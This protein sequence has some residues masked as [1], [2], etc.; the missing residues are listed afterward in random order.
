MD[1]N[2]NIEQTTTTPEQKS[3]LESKL[4][5]DKEHL[6][7]TEVELDALAAKLRE[8]GSQAK[9]KL[10]EDA[11]AEKEDIEKAR[12]EFQQAGDQAR[13]KLDRMTRNAGRNLKNTTIVLMKN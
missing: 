11:R 3:A 8:D 1:D 7:K 4:E 5:A 10:E 9:E 13:A 6:E 12:A 2:K